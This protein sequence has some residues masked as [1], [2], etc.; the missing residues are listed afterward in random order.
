MVI[1][2]F[3]MF[4]AKSQ[5]TQF[6]PYVPRYDVTNVSSGCYLKM[7]GFLFRVE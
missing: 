7:E 3:I 1:I 6:A 2:L 4:S 5:T